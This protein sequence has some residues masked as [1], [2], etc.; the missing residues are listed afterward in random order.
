M[1]TKKYFAIYHGPEAREE[2]PELRLFEPEVEEEISP[3]EYYALGRYNRFALRTAAIPAKPSSG[4]RRGAAVP[5]P[6]SNDVDPDVEDSD[7]E[8]SDVEDSDGVPSTSESVGPPP[9]LAELAALL[10]QDDNR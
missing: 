3:E 6:V 5:S 7:V 9:S 8:D 2:G 4:G 1:T 10:P